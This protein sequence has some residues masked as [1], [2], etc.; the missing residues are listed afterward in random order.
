MVFGSSRLI[1]GGFALKRC[2]S[3]LVRCIG[4]SLTPLL[5]VIGLSM[6][7]SSAVRQSGGQSEDG[8]LVVRRLVVVD[9][10][11]RALVT[12]GGDD[13]S[14]S[15]RMFDLDGHEA[16]VLGVEQAQAGVAS[17]VLTGP[18]GR[19]ALALR[20]EAVG[21]E[22]RVAGQREGTDGD[23]R[24][25]GPR[26]ALTTSVIMR[27]TPGYGSVQ[28]SADSAECGGIGA[29]VDEKAA[30]GYVSLARK[31]EFEIESGKTVWA[32][33]TYFAA[34]PG[35]RVDCPPELIRRVR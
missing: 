34:S 2:C 23:P 28:F 5:A 3:F 4:R 6:V 26:Q 12:I 22:I 33:D 1:S 10:D 25:D 29:R 16:A 17:L 8:V 31:A 15:L 14:A 13:E 35:G 32:G 11:G 24:G 27:A 19:G 7:L 18:E 20:A 21:A 30:A 9:S